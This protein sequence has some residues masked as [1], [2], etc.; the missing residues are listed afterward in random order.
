[1]ISLTKLVEQVRAVT[2]WDVSLWELLKAGERADAMARI[3]NVREGF[4]PEDDKLPDRLFDPMPG[5][6]N[7]ER[8]DPEDFRKAKDAYYDMAGWD[9]QTGM[10]TRARLM[11]LDLEWT[12]AQ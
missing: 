6:L 11:D 3:F 10:P 1:H 7:G 2:G 4:T 12:V 9:H 5:P 8:I